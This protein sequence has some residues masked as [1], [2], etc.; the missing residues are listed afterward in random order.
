MQKILIG[1]E[2]SQ[3]I[4][5]EL[6]KLG[7]EAYS[8]DLLPCSGSMP[9]HHLK[10]DIFK[11]ID[12]KKWDLIILHPPCTAI[13][14]SGNAWYGKGKLRH[15]ERIKA[16]EWTLKL[17]KYATFKCKKVALE[18][19]VGVL[20]STGGGA[21]KTPIHTTLAIW[22]WRNQKNGILAL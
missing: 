21:S 9:E 1:C 20:N 17:W 18:N 10:M 15:P 14:V 22:A 16:I 19:P 2:E 4:T 11:A 8:C 13:A 12:L 6:R 7:Y 5:V 3:T